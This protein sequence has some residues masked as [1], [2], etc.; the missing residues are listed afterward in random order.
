MFT[1]PLNN[2]IEY[3]HPHDT[4]VAI[5]NA[6]NNFEK[7]KGNALVISGGPKQRMRY[8]DMLGAILGVMGLPLPPDRKFTKEPYYLDWYDTSR[9]QELLK[10]QQRGF[11]DYLKDYTKELARRYGPGFVPFMRYFISPV[12]GKVIVQFF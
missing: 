1:I 8:R 11:G 10:F 4:A 9:S 5:L 2:R 7:V 6:V 3:C 12:M